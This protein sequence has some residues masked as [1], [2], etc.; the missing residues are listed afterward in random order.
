MDQEKARQQM[1]ALTEKLNSYAHA[2]YVLDQPI[3]T[4]AE[5]DEAYQQLLA[6]EKEYPEFRLAESPTQR[7]GGVADERFE[8]IQHDET[9]LSLDDVFSQEEVE[10]FI[11]RT[12]ESLGADTTYV[13]ELKIDGLSVSLRYDGGRLTYGATRGDGQV[14]EDITANI[15]TIPSIPL[16]L[17]EP[18][19]VTVRGEVYM[20]KAAFEALNEE[21]EAEGQPTFANPRNSAAGS[22]R[23]LDS[24]ITAKRQ[25]N[26]FLYASHFEGEP[27]VNTQAELLKALPQWGLRVNPNYALCQNS[28]EIWQYIEAMAEKRHALPYDIDGVV[29][30]VNDFKEQA[31][32]GNTVRAPRWATAYKF[33]AE[34]AQTT[35]HDIEW[36][37]GRTGVV[38]PTA[39]MEPVLLAGSVVQRASLHN[40]DYI[41]EKDL[42]LGDEVLIH[43]AGDIIPE[44]IK[45]LT[46]HR[47][48]QAKPY[49]IPTHCPACDSELIHLEDEVA[50]RCINLACPAQAKEKLYHFVSRPAMDIVG[51]GPKMLEKCYEAELVQDPSDLYHLTEEDLLTLSGVKEKTA[52]NILIAITDSKGQSLERLLFGLGI[53][54]IGQKACRDLAREFGDLKHLIEAKEEDIAAVPGFGAI[55]A[56]S[57]AEA[58]GN[59]D[60][61]A[62][63]ER[64]EKAGVNTTYEGESRAELAAKDTFWQG[65]SVVL[66]GKLEH[67]T[68]QEAKAAIEAEGGKVTGS[69]SKNTDV[70]VAGADAGSK[71]SR[72][73]QLEITIFNEQEMREKLPS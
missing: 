49:E 33:P 23:Q 56:Q 73:Q 53:R 32:L 41:E 65:K 51:L 2:Y 19:D 6:L 15:K 63:L 70:V 64:L 55:M 30:K 7:V 18:L 8:K 26:V 29:I 58:F 71:L 61:L 44:V 48:D 62:L 54:H 35:L 13:C 11:R 60:I 42:R 69:V 57:V 68:R 66:T 59:E 9:L 47:D 24:R 14:G 21:R 34:Q 27:A 20:P 46:D 12:K 16:K 1:A 4:D 10:A 36:T 52:T 22:V 37:V 67:Y 39:V 45:V 38:T 31:Q 40:A 25:L 17:S 72:A 3:A 5:Y 50:L 28:E 43:K